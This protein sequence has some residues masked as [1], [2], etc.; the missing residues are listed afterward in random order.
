[1]YSK[2]HRDAPK[3][4]LINGVI[5]AMSPSAGIHHN[6]VVLSIAGIFARYLK[7]KPCKVFTDSVDVYLTED[8]IFVPDVTVVCNPN[9]L[10]PKG[11]YGAPDLVVEILSHSTAKRDK[12]VKKDIYGKCGVKEYWIVD[13]RSLSVEVYLIDSERLEFDNRY[14]IVPPDWIAEST[15]DDEEARPITKFKTSLFD[16]L[17]IDLEEVFAEIDFDSELTWNDE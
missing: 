2:S 6:H 15:G 5:V 17:I 8:N 13:I 7:G 4:E 9:I 3:K 11:I 10:K 1:M 16:D 12:G 14:E